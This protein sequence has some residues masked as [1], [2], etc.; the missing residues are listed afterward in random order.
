M[1]SISVQSPFPGSSEKAREGGVLESSASFHFTTSFPGQDIYLD[2]PIATA[3]LTLLL[4]TQL[5][6]I[7]PRDFKLGFAVAFV[8]I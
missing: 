7:L 4:P 2:L 1:I 3:Y 5:Y 8:I 6:Q